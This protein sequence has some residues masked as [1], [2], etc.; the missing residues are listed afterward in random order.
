MEKKARV[1]VSLKKGVLDPQ[2]EAVLQA[3]CSLGFS[4]ISEVRVGK[5]IELTFRDTQQTFIQNEVASMAKKLLANPVME[6]FEV[7]ILP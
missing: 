2:G 7:E 1:R 5:V 4:G 3:L 6:D